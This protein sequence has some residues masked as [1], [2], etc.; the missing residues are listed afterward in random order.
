MDYYHAHKL[1]DGEDVYIHLYQDPEDG[2]I[3]VGSFK[4]LQ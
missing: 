1:M 4:Q 2:S 3:V